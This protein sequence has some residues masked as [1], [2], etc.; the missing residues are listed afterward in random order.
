M[1]LIGWTSAWLSPYL[2]TPLTKERRMSLV[3]CIRKRKYNFTYQSHQSLPYAAP[4]FKDNAICVLSKQEWDEIMSEA[5]R[6]EP[7]GMR[8]MP[9]DVIDIKPINGVLYEKEK[10]LPKD[11]END[12]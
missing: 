4:L 11:G 1:Q 8:L 12:E 6:D 9:E 7:L 5:Y 2:Q 10:W 3:G